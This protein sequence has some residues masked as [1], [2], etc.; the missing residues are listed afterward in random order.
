[1]N[2]LGMCIPASASEMSF[3]NRVVKSR[4]R[5]QI[6]GSGPLEHLRAPARRLQHSIARLEQEPV[7]QSAGDVR[8]HAIEN[9]ASLFYRA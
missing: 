8:F 4:R 5:G 3:A 2:Q 6:I 7:E 9:A 1:M